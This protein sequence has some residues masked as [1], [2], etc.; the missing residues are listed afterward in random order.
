MSANQ[1]EWAWWLMGCVV[2]YRLLPRALL[3]ALCLWRWRAGTRRLQGQVDMADR[4][5]QRHGALHDHGDGAQQ[6][7]HGAV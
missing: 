1:R 6:G 4:L 7:D 2:V 5:R 3:A